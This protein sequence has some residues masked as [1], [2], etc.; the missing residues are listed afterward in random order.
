MRGKA[1][2]KSPSQKN[3]PKLRKPSSH[4]PPL[5]LREVNRRNVPTIPAVKIV[6][7]RAPADKRPVSIW[8]KLYTKFHKGTVGSGMPVQAI[9]STMYLPGLLLSAPGA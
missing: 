8:E 7:D 6:R 2:A 3:F 1:K 5:K 4:I 9:T